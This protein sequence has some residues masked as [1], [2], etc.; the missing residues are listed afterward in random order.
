MIR[1]LSPDE[2]RQTMARLPHG[3]L[4]VVTDQGPYAVPMLFAVQ[5]GSL[6]LYA[7]PGRLLT[8]LRGHPLGVVVEFDWIE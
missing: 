5:A 3:R 7:L 8:A 2:C 1:A 6:A 4:A